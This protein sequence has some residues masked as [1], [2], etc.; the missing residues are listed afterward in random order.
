VYC[1]FIASTHFHFRIRPFHGPTLSVHFHPF[2]FK[3]GLL[4][5]SNVTASRCYHT[6]G[7]MIY[8]SSSVKTRPN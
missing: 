1:P 6:E 2:H 5:L 7:H 3:V 8:W 4:Y